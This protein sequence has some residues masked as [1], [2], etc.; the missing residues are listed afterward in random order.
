MKRTKKEV[1]NA[2]LEKMNY[3]NG[4]IVAKWK[5]AF[6]PKETPK[7]KR[8]GR[9]VPEKIPEPKT[10]EPALAMIQKLTVVFQLERKENPVDFERM[11]FVIRA[12]SKDNTRPYL[13]VLHVEETKTGSRLVAS[14]G[15]RL[16]VAEISTRIKGGN[17]KPVMTKEAIGISELAE[18]V[19]YLNWQR[20]IP[21]NAV[22]R[23][24]INLEPYSLSKDPK[25]TEK[26][27]IA[28]NALMRQTGETVNLR[29]LQDM[30]KTKWIVHS[31]DEQGKA[32]ILKESG[33]EKTVYAVLMP[34]PPDEVET[35]IS[36]KAA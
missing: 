5:K 22:Q 3:P 6:P 31:Q 4:S 34:L 15:R 19:Q 35:A 25:Q 26:L 23:G 24:V 14:D 11:A 2:V 30:T 7:Q 8:A 29:Y 21:D 28:V 36:E 32:L 10:A 1:G 27:S 13:C 18:E 12:C 16:H 20:V 33:A 17:Y 9:K